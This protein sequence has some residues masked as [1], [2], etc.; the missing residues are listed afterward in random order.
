VKPYYEHAGITI[1]HG[2]CGLWLADRSEIECDMILTDPPYGINGMKRGLAPGTDSKGAY[3]TET[4]EDTQ[5]YVTE[6]VVPTIIGF[7]SEV[8]RLV[9]TP[10]QVNIHSYP[11]PDHCGVFYYPA[12]TSISRWGMRLWQPIFYYGRDPYVNELRP[13]SKICYDSDRDT[14]HPCPKPTRLLDLAAR[15]GQPSQ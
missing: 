12:S 15:A 4:F 10:G 2:D 3:N 14:D 9:L 11:K 6:F 13:D 1:Y 8:P 5:E 7:L